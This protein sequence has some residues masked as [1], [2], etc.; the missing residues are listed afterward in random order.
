VRQLKHD[1]NEQVEHVQYEEASTNGVSAIP[2]GWI[3]ESYHHWG[4]FV[5]HHNNCLYTT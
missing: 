5:L 1:L 2:E 3:E 4:Q